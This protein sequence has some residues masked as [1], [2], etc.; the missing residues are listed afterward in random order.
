MS[1][2]FQDNIRDITDS[3]INL[4]EDRKL[5]ENSNIQVSDEKVVGIVNDLFGAGKHLENPMMF[6]EL[7]SL[8]GI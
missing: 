3:L 7:Q 2:L 6:S 4:C 1:Y 5:D 8:H